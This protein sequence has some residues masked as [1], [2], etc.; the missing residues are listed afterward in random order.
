MNTYY[1]AFVKAI[2]ENLSAVVGVALATMFIPF[3]GW[4]VNKLI[5]KPEKQIDEWASESAL[6]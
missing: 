4:L 3:T 6:H 5:Q 1:E 2:L